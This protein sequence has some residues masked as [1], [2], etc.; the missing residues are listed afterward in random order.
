M[1]PPPSGTSRPSR[2]AGR[3]GSPPSPNGRPSRSSSTATP[4]AERSRA[5]TV[6]DVVD[7]AAQRW[8]LTP[9][10]RGNPD[11]D[12]DSGAHSGPGSEGRSW[13]AGNDVRPPVHGAAYFGRL[14]EE[15]CALTAGDRLYFT[16]WRG[17]ADERL[18]ESGPTIVDVLC[19]LARSGVE[20]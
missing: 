2:S 10:E 15:L 8:L 20:V 6:A 17:D 18:T 3:G 1:P 5:G 16:D 12:L 4:D 11:T 14:Y 19:D 9:G 7:A 13:S